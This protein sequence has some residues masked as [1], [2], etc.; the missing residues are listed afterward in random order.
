MNTWV[1]DLTT[2]FNYNMAAI[3]GTGDTDADIGYIWNATTAAASTYGIDERVILAMIMQESG[4]YVGIDAG[5]GGVSA[6]IMQCAGS[7]Q[8]PGQLDLSYVS[9]SYY[10][11]DYS[12]D[13][14][15]KGRH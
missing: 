7:P 10:C 6:G 11:L 5:D 13:F 14:V 15:H 2:L 3:Q 1:P 12:T 4:A 8:Y 9:P